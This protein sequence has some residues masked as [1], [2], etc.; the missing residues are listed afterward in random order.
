MAGNVTGVL[1]RRQKSANI[2]S[3]FG[4]HLDWFTVRGNNKVASFSRSQ[5]RSV[6]GGG[7]TF[8]DKFAGNVC[9]CTGYEPIIDA[10]LD[11]ARSDNRR[12]A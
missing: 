2:Q 11:A 12:R 7:R 4:S 1:L 8:L 6:A 3:A 10:V 9:R 5:P